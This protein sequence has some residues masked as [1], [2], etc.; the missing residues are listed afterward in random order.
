MGNNV[1]PG[2]CGKSGPDKAV[3]D[4]DATTDDAVH[5]HHKRFFHGY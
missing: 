4:I 1:K 2:A 3:L 5:N